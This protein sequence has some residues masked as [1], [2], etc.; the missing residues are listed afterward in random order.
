[1]SLARTPKSFHGRGGQFAHAGTA[2]STVNLYWDAL[3]PKPDRKK[4]PGL[5]ATAVANDEAAN[6]G[7]LRF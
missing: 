6:R 4:V 3:T 1:M 2:L 7:G 5:I